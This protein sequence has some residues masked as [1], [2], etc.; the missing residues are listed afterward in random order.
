MRASSAKATRIMLRDR[1]SVSDIS[2]DGEIIIEQDDPTADALIQHV[3]ESV[4]VSTLP[5]AAQDAIQRIY[6]LAQERLAKQ[7]GVS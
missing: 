4:R 6:G 2:I 3:A 1:G 5:P 7:Y